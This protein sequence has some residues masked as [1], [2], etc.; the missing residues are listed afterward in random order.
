MPRAGVIA[1]FSDLEVIMLSMAFEAIGI[2]S[3]PFFFAKLQE[4]RE[5]IS[6][7]ISG[8]QYNGKRKFAISFCGIASF[9]PSRSFA[10]RP[11]TLLV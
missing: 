10:N 1:K 8:R 7:L 3:E 6:R 9:T 11:Y 4:C 5:E 2:D